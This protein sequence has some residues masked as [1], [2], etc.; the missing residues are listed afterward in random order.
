[1]ISIGPI[2]RV[3]PNEIHVNDANYVTTV[4]ATAAK[5]RTDIIPPR[6][7][8]MDGKCTCVILNVTAPFLNLTKTRF[9]WIYAGPRHPRSEK[10]TN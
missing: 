3:S 2:V 10:E 9:Y 1:M 7:L 4:F 5:H 8:G 6:G